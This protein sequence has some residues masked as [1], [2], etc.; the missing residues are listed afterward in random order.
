MFCE[1]WDA[2]S[3]LVYIDDGRPVDRCKRQYGTGRGARGGCE[4]AGER[5]EAS[6]WAS[7]S[8]GNGPFLGT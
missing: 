3:T 6:L 8:H 5:E 2:A 1:V 4:C 7:A